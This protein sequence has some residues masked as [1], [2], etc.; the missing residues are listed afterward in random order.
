MLLRFRRF[1]CS[2][3]RLP[4][5]RPNITLIDERPLR[6]APNGI[7]DQSG[8]LHECDAIIYAT[9]F[10]VHKYLNGLPIYGPGGRDLQKEWS[11]E[12]AD[13]FYGMM[14]AGFPNL[15]ISQGP[16]S[17][18]G[19]QSAFF[20]IECQVDW[21]T[22][23]LARALLLGYKTVDV[24]PEA[25]KAFIEWFDENMKKMIWTDTSS[26]CGSY[27]KVCLLRVAVLE[28]EC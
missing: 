19:T 2:T 16:R 5:K 25:Q 21:I 26:G 28:R 13:T 27:Y 20:S 15:F 6:I 3:H 23:V 8:T 18:L 14:V 10:H 9:G 24:K 4:V 1:T 11:N 17:F 22:Q 7:I 12:R